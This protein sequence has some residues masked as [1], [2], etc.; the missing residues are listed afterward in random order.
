MLKTKVSCT[1]VSFSNMTSA[2]AMEEACRK[3]DMPGSIIPVPNQITA[4][5]GF[6][7]RASAEDREKIEDFLKEKGLTRY[8]HLNYNGTFLKGSQLLWKA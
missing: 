4:S 6:A 7:W 8:T 3:Y 2:L 1:V 5:C